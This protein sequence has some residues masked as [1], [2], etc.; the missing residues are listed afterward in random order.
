VAYVVNKKQ[1]VKFASLSEIRKELQMLPPKRLQELALRMAR[2]KKENKELLAFLL[3]ED[4][5]KQ[6]F[7][8]ELKEE[9]KAEFSEIT[10]QTNLYYMKKGLRRI[11]RLLNRYIRYID[12]KTIAVELLIWFCSQVREHKLPLRSSAQMRNLFEQQIKKAEKL[13]ASLHEDIQSD[14]FRE[15]GSVRL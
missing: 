4:D 5:N 15:L 11:L 12:D 7:I 1:P 6:S 14:Y 2:Y 10:S 9:L 3:F 13:V 8:E